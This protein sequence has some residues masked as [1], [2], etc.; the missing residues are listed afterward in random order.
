MEPQHIS[1]PTIM[2][3]HD[4][5][6]DVFKVGSPLTR[7][8][9]LYH[10]ENQQPMMQQ[11]NQQTVPFMAQKVNDDT[12]QQLKLG[13][14]KIMTVLERLEQRI[15][16]VE[17]TTSQILK[18][19]Q[20][21]F[22]VPFM[23]QTE[24]DQARN[25]AEQLE[26]DNTVAKQLQAA[27]N[28]ETELKKSRGN[29]LH[30][31]PICGVRVNDVELE[32]HVD[33]CLEMFSNDPKKEAQLKDAKTKI[34][35]GFFSKV[36]GLNKVNKTETTTTTTKTVSQSAIPPT[37]SMEHDA[38]GNPNQNMYGYGGYSPYQGSPRMSPNMSPNMNGGNAPMMMPMYM[39]PSYPVTPHSQE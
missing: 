24:I 39:Y 14:A 20:E 34:E 3:A 33:K 32:V 18:N 7:P 31:C 15:T 8:N 23:S 11:Q 30:E 17:Q 29:A 1:Y 27:F 35:S 13:F 2:N 26:R 38:M 9:S 5:F 21:V 16:K 10:H 6:L 28:K 25:I 4:D 22:Q 12:L 37:F 19:Q 36:F